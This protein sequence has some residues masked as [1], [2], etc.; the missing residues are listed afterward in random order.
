MV[1]LLQ[2]LS[3]QNLQNLDVQV[4]VQLPLN[5]LYNNLVHRAFM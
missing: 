5:V 4:N 2:I 1:N 3:L